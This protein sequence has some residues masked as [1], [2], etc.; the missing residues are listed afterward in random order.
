VKRAPNSE[1]I[2]EII[3]AYR[4]LFTS[5]REI[6][7]NLIK[8]LDP[9][10]LKARYRDE[11]LE[12]HPDRAKI[13]GK[14]EIEMAKRFT[15]INLAYEKLWKFITENKKLTPKRK[16]NWKN[17]RGTHYRRSTK[18]CY[19]GLCPNLELPIGQFLFY[20]GHISWKTLLDAILWQ[21]AQRPSFGEIAKDWGILTDVDIIAIQRE[22]KQREK[23][24]EFALNKG[25]INLLQHL[26]ILGKQRKIQPLIGEFFVKSGIIS[27]DTMDSMIEKQRIHNLRVR[28][29]RY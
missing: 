16:H 11:A 27:K 14:S 10:V 24:G 22:K 2:N 3:N 12:N 4:L 18:F 15:E 1:Y 20:T 7:I 8:F 29:Q 26:A 19:S 13:L 5:S 21:R 6:S 25:Y 17:G 28:L 23:F 9:S